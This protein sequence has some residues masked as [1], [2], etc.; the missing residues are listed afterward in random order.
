MLRLLVKHRQVSGVLSLG[1]VSF[2]SYPSLLRVGYTYASRPAYRSISSASASTTTATT[3][4]TATTPQPS[5]TTASVENGLAITDSAVRQLK[6]IRARDN[7]DQSMLR[8]LVD[9]GGC[10]GYQNKLELTREV[11]EDDIV[12][13]KDGVRVVVDSISLAFVRGSQVDF[14]EEL[15]GSTFQV[16]DNPNATHSCGCNISY[17]I[18]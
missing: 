9:S 11:N 12:F 16:K 13:E 17:A 14:V 5:W 10:H 4:T 6:Y 3:A 18:D 2:S 7:D 8:V 15:I 1:K